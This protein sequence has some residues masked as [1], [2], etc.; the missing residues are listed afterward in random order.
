VDQNVTVFICIVLE[1]IAADILNVRIFSNWKNK[2]V[3][4]LLELSNTNLQLFAIH[5]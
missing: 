5:S 3:Q 4:Q 2:I 1:Y